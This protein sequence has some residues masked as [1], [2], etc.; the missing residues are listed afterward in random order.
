MSLLVCL[1]LQPVVNRRENPF[2][3]LIYLNY[4][5]LDEERLKD[6]PLVVMDV[7]F[8]PTRRIIPQFWV[9]LV[10]GVKWI[11]DR[12][13]PFGKVGQEIARP[14]PVSYIPNETTAH[15]SLVDVKWG[16]LI[17]M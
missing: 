13:R 2:S 9:F 8:K 3:A 15:R 6:I 14:V 7:S 11:V 10:R 5:L 4:H 12:A 1:G 17:S 16:A